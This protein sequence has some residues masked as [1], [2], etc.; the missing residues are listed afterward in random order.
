M[1]KILLRP[2]CFSSI[3]FTRDNGSV[4]AI[5]GLVIKFVSLCI[6]ANSERKVKYN[7]FK[8]GEVQDDGK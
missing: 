6:E 5:N 4:G 7:F 3:M 1:L 8:I 2:L